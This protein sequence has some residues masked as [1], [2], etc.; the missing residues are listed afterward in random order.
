[1]DNDKNNDFDFYSSKIKRIFIPLPGFKFFHRPSEE[2][3]IDPSFI[4]RDRIS[5]KLANW[6]RD[7]NGNKTGAYLIT[8]FRGMGKTSFVGK[9]IDDLKK[10]QKNK[11][12]FLDIICFIVLAAAI[13]SAI[14]YFFSNNYTIQFTILAIFTILDIIFIYSKNPTKNKNII[15]IK[16]NIGNEIMNARDVLSVL[17]YSI[18]KQILFYTNSSLSH[19]FNYVLLKNYFQLFIATIVCLIFYNNTFN[20]LDQLASKFYSRDHENIIIFLLKSINCTLYD[21]FRIGEYANIGNIIG[22][23]ISFLISYFIAKMIIRFFTHIITHIIDIKFSSPSSIISKLTNLCEH[24]DNAINEEKGWPINGTNF[25]F[26][27]ISTTQKKTKNKQ[28][29]SVREIEQELVSIINEINNCVYLQCRLIIV[30]DELDKLHKPE[31]PSQNIKDYDSFPEFTFNENGISKETSSN[32]K[33]H[34]ILSLLGQLKFFIS[35]AEAKF[36]F[37]AGHELYDAYLADVSDRE[38][39]VNSIFNGVINVDSF[40][41][42]DYGIKDI[43]K[44][45]EAYVCKHLMH[46]KDV[47][48]GLKEFNHDIKTFNLKEYYKQIQENNKTKNQLQEREIESVIAFLRQFITYLTFVSNGAPK[49]LTANFEKYIISKKM[50]ETQIQR[51]R[52][53]D[54][55]L[56]IKLQDDNS[57]NF[58][59]AFGYYDQQK[60]GFI[61]YL[62]CPI[63]ENIINPASESG[64]KLLVASSF[65]FAHI[66]KHHNSGFSWRN[67]EYM[68]ELLN[69]SNR[70]PELR[71]FLDSIISYLGQIYLTQISSGIYS[72]KFPLR[73]ADEITFFSKK[74][75]EL[76]AIFNFSLDY[77]LA[78]KKYYYKLFDYYKNK[79]NVSDA[80]IGLLHHNLGDIHLANDEYTEAIAQ[81][82]LTAKAID[83]YLTEYKPET[84][85]KLAIDITAQIIRYTRVMLKLGL[86]YEKRNT[87]DSAFIIY[88]TL[89]SKLISFREFNERDLKLESIIVKN[90]NSDNRQFCQNNK[91]VLLIDQKENNIKTSDDT[92][93]KHPISDGLISE[94]VKFWIYGEELTDNLCDMLTPKKHALISKLSV[95]EDL[96]LAYLPILAKLF[97]LEKHNICG[98]TKDNIKV[99]EAEFQY[100]FLLTNSKEKY[101]LNVDFF[102]KLGD[103]LYYK[104]NTLYQLGQDNIITLLALWGYD[105][106]NTIYDYCYSKRMTKN[107]TE[108]IMK[109][110]DEINMNEIF[111]KKIYC[112]IKLLLNIDIDINKISTKKIKDIIKSLPDREMIL[113]E[114][115]SNS[116]YDRNKLALK[117]YIISKLESNKKNND[118]KTEQKRHINNI[119]DEIPQ[120]IIVRINSI[121]ECG[122]LRSENNKHH[123][124]PCAACRY[125]NRSISIMLENLIPNNYKMYNKT[126]ALTFLIALKDD[127]LCSYRYNELTQTA[128]TLISLGNVLLSCSQKNKDNKIENNFIEYLFESDT[129][130]KNAK[131]KL[132]EKTSFSHLEKTLLY[133]WTAMK[134]YEKANNFKDSAQCLVWIF[135]VLSYY[136]SRD[137]D[138]KLNRFD[139]ILKQPVINQIIN[140]HHARE[141]RDIP[142]TMLLRDIIRNDTEAKFINLGLTS[143]MPDLEE[144]IL[145]YYEILLELSSREKEDIFLNIVNILYNSTSLTSIRNESLSYNRVI[146]LYFKARLNERIL[147]SIINT[148][149]TCTDPFSLKNIHKEHIKIIFNLEKHDYI[150]KILKIFNLKEADNAYKHLLFFLISDSIFCLIKI[151]DF[152][153]T[154]IRTTLFTNSFCHDIYKLLSLWVGIKE[155]F[156][157]I[158]NKE[159][160]LKEL[161]E[162]FEILIDGNNNKFLRKTYLQAMSDMYLKKAESIHTE[163]AEYKEFIKTMYL[164]DDDLQN[165]TC[166]FYFALERCKIN[167]KE[168][169]EMNYKDKKYFMP[170]EYLNWKE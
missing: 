49:K 30:F 150:N 2:N 142:E 143:I 82:R 157:A 121:A 89:T 91:R 88:S 145:G 36:I 111:T 125:Y 78:V 40:F 32:E 54:G 8:G 132:I 131:D 137:K 16:V 153:E 163:G 129:K 83:A 70:T 67:L 62:V 147:T 81:Y 52:V 19:S 53:N 75:E 156:F 152:L 134:Y 26:I 127:Q 7:D 6:L 45:T 128:L 167:D 65:L 72:Y 99:A 102:R 112:L 168:E 14:V 15:K 109:L 165:D 56:T 154:T 149:N 21:K 22:L 48:N 136:L 27:N 9:V 13:T 31:E 138:F 5:E 85:G 140:I 84:Q 135:N 64:D 119:I 146:S 98:I 58:Y 77:S 164:L 41:S 80:I 51:D 37:I 63:F 12:S 24:I 124:R 166:Q 148:V 110:F 50:Y 123:T 103:I 68:P 105:F 118:I 18:K 139:E 169:E 87:F 10:K 46:Q 35:S 33:K 3:D 79:Q 107:E 95:F 160:E 161:K 106:K 162:K 94:K 1:M 39:S 25:S 126:R 20:I 101:M 28:P 44:L 47:D 59:L 61:H 34:R 113:Q 120:N 86:A 23:L 116:I 60:I 90:N 92:C 141:F 17:A 43:T 133:Y 74:S 155:E 130:W 97:A 69:S 170:E 42:C 4:G 93:H 117:E 57:F 114:D 159:K 115:N 71:S 122:I 76:S 38:F 96:R 158:V 104:N 151:T 29:A 73:L 55:D 144:L 100:M 108:D 11:T 66:L